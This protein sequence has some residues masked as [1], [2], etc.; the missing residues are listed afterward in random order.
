MD[1]HPHSLSKLILAIDDE[2]EILEIIKQCLEMEGFQV[3]TALGPKEGLKLYETRGT[4]VGV[5][6]LDYLMPD[7]TGDL[8]FE[9]LRQKNP[10]ARV[11]LLTGCEDSVARKMFEAGLRGFIQKP[12]YIDD[13]V[14]RVREELSQD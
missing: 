10:D 6:L 11:I 7:M 8:V 9:C 1:L 2:P 4:E 12:F 3:L 5:V 13:L 14:N